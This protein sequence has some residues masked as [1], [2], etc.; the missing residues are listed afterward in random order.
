M[1]RI[2]L[3]TTAILLCVIFLLPSCGVD[4]KKDLQQLYNESARR[5][6]D[7]IMGAVSGPM[8]PNARLPLLTVS[9]E[10]AP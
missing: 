9:N 3:L 7:S 5:P 10:A 6:T 4:S 8:R 2:L 1:K